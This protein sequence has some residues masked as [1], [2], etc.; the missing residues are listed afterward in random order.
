M[1]QRRKIYLDGSGENQKMK[2]EVRKK[3]EKM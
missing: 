1:K 2:K 3:K